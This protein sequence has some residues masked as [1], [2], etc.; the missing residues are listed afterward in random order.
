MNGQWMGQYDGSDS[1]SVIVNLDDMGDH[2][3]G[4]AFLTSANNKLPAAAAVL[5]TKTKANKFKL[6]TS[7]IFPIDLRTG[8]V[9]AWEQIKQFYP[10][11]TFSKEAEVSGEWD[12]KKLTLKWV[13][14]Q[15]ISGSAKIPK[16]MADEQSELKPQALYRI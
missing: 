16:S 8:V 2:Y 11:I 15:K 6:K 13:T 5:K 1:G 10:N 7:I 12:R 4:V 14:D 3:E 9:T